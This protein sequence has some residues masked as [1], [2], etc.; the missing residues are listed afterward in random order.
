MHSAT[1]GKI[2]GCSL[3]ISPKSP[4]VQRVET[5]Y[6]WLPTAAFHCIWASSSRRF[7]IK[8][9]DASESPACKGKRWPVRAI[10]WI[11]LESWESGESECVCVCFPN[12][13]TF[14]DVF[15]EKNK[16]IKWCQTPETAFSSCW[17]V[18]I[19]SQGQVQGMNPVPFFSW[20]KKAAASSAAKFLWPL[21]SQTS[22]S[23]TVDSHCSKRPNSNRW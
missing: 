4:R 10:A 19:L 15:S 9:T 21:L 5:T 7:S 18:Q 11:Y 8:W 14:D 3:L 12:L 13:L 17:S 2:G 22:K 1:Y 16:Q 6:Q 23:F 20:G